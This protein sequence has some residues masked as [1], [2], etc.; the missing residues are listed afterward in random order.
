MAF[1][2]RH[3][4]TTTAFRIG[5][6]PGVRED[7][8]FQDEEIPNVDVPVEFQDNYFENPDLDRYLETFEQNDPAVAII[9]DAYSAEEAEILNDV[10]SELKEEYPYK[11]LIAVP[12]CREAFEIFSD[13]VT[14]GY[15]LGFSDLDPDDYSN[16]SD[17]RG[18]RTHILGG[19]PDKQYEA[20][21][22]LTG[23]VL[24]G[25]PPADIA[26]VDWNGV[27]KVAYLGEYWSSNGW[28]SADHLS[29]RETVR[30]SLEE[31]KSFWEDRDLWPE[32][33]PI[34]IY[35]EPTDEPDDAIWMDDGGDPISSLEGL[36]EAYI[37]EYEDKG[38]MAFRSESQKKFIEYREDLTKE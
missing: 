28:Q 30:E 7:Y 4:F 13:D 38:K 25:A 11:E 12:K 24:N 18:R 23:P 16:L 31:I 1:T 29:I 32:T 19:A 33:E 35:G 37:G 9:G 10:V 6:V 15:P 22:K 14:L 5:F 36:E 34:D 26:G 27:H 21:Q 3:P 20:I 8:G 2:G 17:W